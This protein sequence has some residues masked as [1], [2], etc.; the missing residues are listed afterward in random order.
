MRV[1]TV[2]AGRVARWL[3]LACTVLGLAAM[4]TLGHGHG[5]DMAAHPPAVAAMPAVT[6]SCPPGHCAPMVTAPSPGRNDMPAWSVCLAVLAGLGVAALLAWLLLSTAAGRAMSA[7][8][9]LRPYGVPRAPPCSKLGLRVV[10]V[11][12]S[13]I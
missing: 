2:I 13:R 4:H 6:D 11:S 10:S 5:H 8:A 7:L 9:V 1:E 3:L 12:V